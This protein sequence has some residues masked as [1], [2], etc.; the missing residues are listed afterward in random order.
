MVLLPT[1]AAVE[2]RRVRELAAN[3]VMVMVVLWKMDLQYEGFGFHV[4]T[5]R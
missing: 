5:R 4:P 2:R 1:D 3:M